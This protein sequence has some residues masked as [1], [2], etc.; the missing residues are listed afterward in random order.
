MA[1]KGEGLWGK[2][3][4]L[5]FETGKGTFLHM[6]WMIKRDPLYSRYYL[7]FKILFNTI[8]F[9]LVAEGSLFSVL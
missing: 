9:K 2:R 4:G 3:D 1:T 5:G 6:E 8:L 7:I